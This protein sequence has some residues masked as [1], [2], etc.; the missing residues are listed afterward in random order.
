MYKMKA[1]GL[2]FLILVSSCNFKNSSVTDSRVYEKDTIN[3]EEVNTTDSVVYDNDTL[4]IYR[5]DS[6]SFLSARNNVKANRDSLPYISD[7]DA[8]KKILK[9]RVV[10][11]GYNSDTHLIDSTLDGE[12]ICAV[13][14]SNGKSIITNENQF[15]WEAGFVR[16]YPSEDI[17]LCEGGHSSDVSI[18]L[19]NGSFGADIVG[20]PE[21]I[22]SSPS[23]KYR[24]NGWFPGQECSDYFL[25]K[26][27]PT[28]Y[29]LFTRIPMDVS[30]EGFD[31]CTLIDIFWLDDANIYFRNT[32][33]EVEDD[34]RLGYFRIMIK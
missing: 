12:M 22:V 21:Y 32:Y 1:I 33:F 5:I 3:L 29:Q 9:G 4:T 19:K 10:F 18:N 11:G 16:Y 24:L 25:Q 34:P 8:A 20:N 13:H 15:F 27:T 28:D 30:K 26:K 6:I 14:F 23:G 2:F 7:F 17:L 31:F